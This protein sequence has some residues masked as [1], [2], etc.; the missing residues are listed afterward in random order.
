MT[1]LS[2][3]RASSSSAAIA[4][5]SARR[6][7]L[8]VREREPWRRE[9]MTLVLDR[10]CGPDLFEKALSIVAG[11]AALAERRGLPMRLITQGFDAS[12]A[13]ESGSEPGAKTFTV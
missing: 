13:R 9:S 6:N 10:G 8:G 12:F 1:G 2:R 11:C 7:A 4:P 5:S 3:S